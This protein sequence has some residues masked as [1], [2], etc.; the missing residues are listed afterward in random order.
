MIY[1]DHHSATKPSLS[2]IERMLVFFKSDW[3]DPLAAHF[4]GQQVVASMQKSTERFSDLLGLNPQDRIFCFQSRFEALSNLAFS[5][6]RNTVYQ[7]G[8]NQIL[9]TNVEDVGSLQV[10][11]QLEEIGCVCRQIAVNEQGQIT[12]EIL[13]EALLPKVSCL[14][15]SW[16]N[17]LTGVIHPLADL[18]ELCKEQGI[19]LHVDA[20]AILGKTYLCLKEIPIDFLTLEG[21]LI[22]APQGTAA[23]IVKDP[24]VFSSVQPQ[25]PASLASLAAAVEENIALFEST[26]LETARLRDSFEEKICQQISDAKVLFAHV[27][28]L[29]NCSVMAF[30]NVHSEALLYLLNRKGV[31]AS[32]GAG[33]YQL[34]SQVLIKCH[35]APEIAYTAISFSL[36]YETTEEEIKAA[37]CVIVDC[38][39]QL[40]KM[41][42]L[43][44]ALC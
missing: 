35:I 9:T 40:K 5:H 26:C 43:K 18:A 38:V 20:S 41:T 19:L 7:T 22:H 33:Q 27:E 13:K 25:M 39:K 14:S 8:K 6:Y 34:L 24:A 12:K 37:V 28:R 42:F 11:Q 15:L 23:M 29:P 30:P 17:S 16:A 31:F 21:S 36:S 3:G 4:M 1:L 10:W 44:E 2:A 32:I